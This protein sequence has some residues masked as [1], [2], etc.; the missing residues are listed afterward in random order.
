MPTTVQQVGS[1]DC[2][3]S[4]EF[5]SQMLSFWLFLRKELLIKSTVHEAAELFMVE[6]RPL[7]ASSSG[8][9]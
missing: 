9:V 4:A 3:L 7:A 2:D 1:Y 6:H 8:A 5:P